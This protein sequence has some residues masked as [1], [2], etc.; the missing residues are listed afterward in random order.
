MLRTNPTEE[1]PRLRRRCGRRAVRERVRSAAGKRLGLNSARSAP[2]RKRYCF[3][4]VRFAG[5]GG[6]VPSIASITVASCS[7]VVK[8][9]GGRR[10]TRVERVQQLEAEEQRR[11]RVREVFALHDA[12]VG[13]GFEHATHRVLHERH[14][15]RERFH[16]PCAKLGRRRRAREQLGEDVLPAAS[17]L[18]VQ[19]ASA[20]F[21]QFGERRDFFEP[22]R[23]TR[24]A[25]LAFVT[26]AATSRSV[27]LPKW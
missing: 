26:A 23:I 5:L 16:E 4:R 14:P 17:L 27:T 9:Y 25:V 18:F 8:S 12:R 3:E 13:S 20:T 7:K 21:D 15:R 6:G 10:G 11:D 2:C 19:F 24:G 1:S 22:R